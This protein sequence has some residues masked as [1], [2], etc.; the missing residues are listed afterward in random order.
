ME[1]DISIYSDASLNSFNMYLS[2]CEW[3]REHGRKDYISWDKKDV[4]PDLL[5]LSLSSYASPIF[6]YRYSSLN[7][8]SF[9]Y[10]EKAC[11][12]DEEINKY[13]NFGGRRQSSKIEVHTIHDIRSSISLMRFGSLY[14]FKFFFRAWYSKMM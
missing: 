6:L 5:L 12:Y 10:P 8:T 9:V 13:H 14:F 4:S 1:K 3:K 2:V 7:Q 11:K